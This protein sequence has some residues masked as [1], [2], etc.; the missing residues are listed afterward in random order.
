MEVG[1]VN[2]SL[3]DV[4]SE[5]W[6]PILKTAIERATLEGR[7]KRKRA[8]E[9]QATPQRMVAANSVVLPKCDGASRAVGKT[10]QQVCHVWHNWDNREEA[11]SG[12]R[13]VCNGG[14]ERAAGDQFV[15]GRCGRGVRLQQRCWAMI[16]K[17]AYHRS[18]R[19][20]S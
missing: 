3:K 12:D 16:M 10:G 4:N 2:I 15:I 19:C 18:V 7:A 20:T 14:E 9:V 11:V 13:A 6:K 1:D 5:T 8:M 17:H